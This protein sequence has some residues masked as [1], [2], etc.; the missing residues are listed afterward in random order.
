MQGKGCMDIG[1]GVLA[2]GEGVT[3]HLGGGGAVQVGVV[4]RIFQGCL[5][6]C[7]AV[8]VVVK[9]HL[10][11]CLVS[12][13]HQAVGVRACENDAV[14]VAH[15]IAFA[16]NDIP[17]GVDLSGVHGHTPIKSFLSWA[18]LR[19]LMRASLANVMLVESNKW[20]I[21]SSVIM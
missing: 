8:G 12:F 2:L 4:H 17:V 14:A 6:R 19:P 1:D 18:T 21:S 16:N 3:A 5:N 10:A 9:R 13:D 11:G 20:I 15:V 7:T